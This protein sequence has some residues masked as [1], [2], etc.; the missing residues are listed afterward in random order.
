MFRDLLG[1]VEFQAG[2]SNMLREGL[3]RAQERSDAANVGPVLLNPRNT[4]SL[5]RGPMTRTEIL[6]AGSPKPVEMPNHMLLGA[7]W[8]SPASRSSS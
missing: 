6:R 3:G 7:I 5:M 4:M 2:Q 1:G 8:R